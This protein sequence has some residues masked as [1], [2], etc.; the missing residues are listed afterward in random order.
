MLCFLSFTWIFSTLYGPSPYFI[1]ILTHHQD[2]RS[3]LHVK[4]SS[5]KVQKSACNRE[6]GAN[7]LSLHSSLSPVLSYET[8]SS[9][10]GTQKEVVSHRSTAYHVNAITEAVI[11]KLNSPRFLP[12]HAHYSNLVNCFVLKCGGKL[13]LQPDQ[14]LS[15]I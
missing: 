10:C 8:N 15:T 14:T 13:Q 2:L 1:P 6:E 3:A 9:F 12:V 7:R 5:E 4:H 11:P